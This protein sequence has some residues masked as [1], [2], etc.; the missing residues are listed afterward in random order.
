M[1]YFFA[2]AI[3]FSV[4]SAE[5]IVIK[6][7]K[8]GLSGTAIYKMDIDQKSY[9]LRIN[10]VESP[11]YNLELALNLEASKIGIAPLIAAVSSN[12]KLVLMEYIDHPTLTLQ[13]AKNNI[14]LLAH[15][16][17]KAHTLPLDIA[18]ESLISKAGRCQ[19][20]LMGID[21]IPKEE[22]EI[23]YRLIHQ[24]NLD[25]AS[26]ESPI[27]CLHGDLNPRNIFMV[28]TRVLFIDFAEAGLGDPFSDLSYL[29]L[30]LDLNRDEESLLLERYLNRSTSNEERKRYRLHKALHLAFWS[31]TDLYL[32]NV[33]LQN[34]PEEGID[35]TAPL[36]DWSKYQELFANGERL[37]AQYF[38]ERS[39][40]NL[41]KAFESLK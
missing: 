8:G 41:K 7:L 16:L 29:S 34:N 18:G 30:K 40:L 17:C 9:V 33:E 10:Q 35:K 39:Q 38:Y 27:V 2:A 26:Y 12:Q 22:I 23:A 6:E 14:P 4:L 3:L 13:E 37:S 36:K 28:D 21:W 20:Y 15:A 31:L 25:L 32:A 11:Q 5:E 24:L 1:N 19:T